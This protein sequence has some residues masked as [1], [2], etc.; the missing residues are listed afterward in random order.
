MLNLTPLPKQ[1]KSYSN[2][3]SEQVVTWHHDKHQAGY[4]TKF[5]EILEQLEKSDKSKSN[6]NYSDFGELKRRLSFNHAGI[7]LHENYWQV[8]GTSEENKDLNV[9]ELEIYGQIEEDFGSF[10]NWKADFEATAKSSLGWAILVF[11]TLTQKLMNVSV[12][13]HNNGA[14][15][16]SKVIIALDVFEHA[17]YKDYGPDRASYIAKFIE[18]LDWKSINCIFSCGDCDECDDCECKNDITEN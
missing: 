16:D 10:D 15:W 4:V 13:F 2:V 3:L 18:N 9:K 6:A 1:P 12:D 7:L 17:Y 11:D 14:I 8:F 5:N